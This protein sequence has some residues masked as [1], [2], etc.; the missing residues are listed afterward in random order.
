M[1]M[2]DTIHHAMTSRHYGKYRGQVV[3]NVD[4]VSRGRLKVR[5]PMLLDEQA[6]WALPCAPYAGPNVGF[7]ALPP[8]DAGVWVEFEGGDLNE[9]IWSGCFWADGQ[10]EAA[11]AAPAVKFWITDSVSIRIDDDAGEIVIK[12][13]GATL[14]LTS[15]E[16]TAEANTITEKAMSS[17]TQ[18][19]ASGFDVNNGAFTVI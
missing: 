18:V 8:R 12:T 11:D 4:P 5:V 14:T 6:V 9:P 10:I 15:S 7:F 16:I 19:S 17:Q 2:D 3:D 13:Q 1:T